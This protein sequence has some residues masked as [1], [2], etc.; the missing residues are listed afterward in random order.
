VA[1]D[2]SDTLHAVE[3]Y[4]QK[5]GLF[6]TV[7]IGEPKQPLGQGLHAAIWMNSVAISLVYAGGDTRENH[8][9]TLRIYKDMLA[10]QTDPQRNLEA[11]MAVATSKLLSNLLGDTDLESTV[12]SLDAAG[13]D[14][15]GIAADFGYIDVGGVMFRTVDIVLPIIVNGSA[16]LA[17]TGV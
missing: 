9:A 8:I 2:I 15:T 14:G 11:E 7:R 4:I 13:M 3:T 1:F 17:G 6:N 10:E 5:L 16:T 12:M